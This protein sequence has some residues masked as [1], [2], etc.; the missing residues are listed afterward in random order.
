M[1][2]PLQDIRHLCFDKDGVLTDVH[3]Y[4]AYNSLLRARR[5]AH[6]FALGEGA[7]DGLLEAMGIIPG[8]RRIKLGGPVGYEPR[9]VI[10]DAVVSHLGASSAEEI[11]ALFKEL[12]G[13]QQVR[14]DY[15]VSVLPGVREFLSRIDVP[16][17]IYTSDRAENTRR[18]LSSLGLA[19]RFVTVIGGGDV[20]RPK[21][22]PEGFL[23]ACAA[24]G[25][26]AEQSAY[27]SDTVS[28][29]AMAEAGGA[30]LRIGVTTGL[31]D[32]PTLAAKAHAV[33]SRLD[34]LQ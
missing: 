34:E 11:G 23:K 27:I 20:V 13:E 19:D 29:M 26:P 33:V 2:S 10:I 6:R 22:D 31:D 5:V 30:R 3:A 24:V 14:D 15:Q 17:T 32:E 4:W 12:D 1:R 18:V 7:V 25:V 21:P 16:L 28:D 8:A 9:P